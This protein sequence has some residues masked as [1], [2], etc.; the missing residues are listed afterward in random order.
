MPNVFAFHAA[1]S[2]GRIDAGNVDAESVE[3]ARELLATRGLY[4]LEL[5]DDGPRRLQRARIRGADLALGLCILA[6]LLESGLSVTRALHALEDLAPG[7]WRGALPSIQQSI[8]EGSGLASALS[9]APIAIPPLVVGIIQAGEGGAGLASAI[10]QAAQLAD[11]MVETRTA[12]RAALIYPA[13]V[14]V[15]GVLAV[16]VLVTVVLPRFAMILADLG[17]ELPRST[18]IV[19]QVATVARDA[20]APASVGAALMLILAKIVFD[21]PAGRRRRDR[22]LLALPVVGRI[23]RGSA[24][25]RLSQSLSAL[26]ETGVPLTTALTF[27]MR[28]I[29]DAELEERLVSVR[30][31]VAGGEALSSALVT[32]D[33]AT[34]TTARLVR[35]GEE[36]GRLAAMLDH[37]SRIERQ[38]TDRVIRNLVRLLEPGLLLVFASIVAFVAAALL[39]AI[40]SVRPGAG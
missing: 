33:A 2:D 28:S 3:E 11:A 6:D 39:Q 1:T 37:A 5:T 20:L 32:F 10:R 12:V 36:S 21:S 23:R 29:G 38:S 26:L 24:V 27:A 14:A 17:Q 22:I 8:K 19:L 30:S 25:G 15:A 7:S 31:A 34:A 4:P 16:I 40:Y 13:I 18:R 9:C 35:A